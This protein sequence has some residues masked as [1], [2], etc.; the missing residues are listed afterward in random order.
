MGRDEALDVA[1]IFGGQYLPSL[2]LQVSYIVYARHGVS[3]TIRLPQRN[4]KEVQ[5]NTVNNHCYPEIIW[6]CEMC[7]ILMALPL[8][9]NDPLAYKYTLLNYT[10]GAHNA[11]FQ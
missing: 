7:V 10:P 4:G 9:R 2:L 8:T 3:R 1:D 6:S 5:V 11:P